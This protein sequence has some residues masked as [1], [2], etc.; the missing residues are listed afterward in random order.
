[1][2]PSIP[3]EYKYFFKQIYLTHNWEPVLTVWVRVDLGVMTMKGYST[4]P[5]SP[6]LEPHHKMQFSVIP[7]TPL[8]KYYDYNNED[9]DTE[10]INV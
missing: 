2:A 8:L 1:M 6:E 3:T 5:R 7:K 9:E 10:L 4:F